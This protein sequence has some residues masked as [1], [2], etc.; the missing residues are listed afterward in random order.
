MTEAK[1]KDAIQGE[2][3]HEYDGIEEAD[4]ALPNWW[5]GI[6][7]ATVLFAVGYWF[8]YHEFEVAPTPRKQL[9]V[10]LAKIQATEAAAPAITDDKLVAMS[11]DPAVVAAGKTTFMT[12]C[13]ACHDAQGQGKIGPNLT[14]KFWIHGGAPTNL[15]DTVTKGVLTAGMPSWEGPLGK[16]GVQKVVA[17]VLTLR[18]TNVPGKAPQ[19][20]PWPPEPKAGG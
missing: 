4:N 7:F 13:V 5:L 1:R 11:E 3:V 16:P 12:F 20:D 15:L 17:Y 9:E 18:N 10:D 8:Y 14:D 2:I 19:G 6:F